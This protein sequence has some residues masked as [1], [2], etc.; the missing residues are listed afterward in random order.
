M[1]GPAITFA[2]VLLLMSIGAFVAYINHM[3][4]SIRPENILA[5][6]AAETRTLIEQRPDSA[7]SAHPLHSTTRGPEAS[8]SVDRCDE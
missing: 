2:F 3:A 5:S 7:T 6:V 8:G 1:P 4:Q